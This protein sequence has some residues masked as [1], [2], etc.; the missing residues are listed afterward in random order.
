MDIDRFNFWQTLPTVLEAISLAN[1]VSFDLEMSGIPSSVGVSQPAESTFYHLAAEAAR[2]FQILQVGLT[3]LSYDCKHKG[4]EARTFTFQLTPE[5]F[6]PNTTLAKLIDRKLVLSYRSF[7]FLKENNF[8]FEKTFSQGVPYL[9]R[10]EGELANNLYLTKPQN[11]N[12]ATKNARP[13]RSWDSEYKKRHDSVVRQTGKPI[14][15][16]PTTRPKQA[17][18]QTR[19]PLHH[20]SPCRRL[21]RRRSRPR[22]TPR[23]QAPPTHHFLPTIHRLPTPPK[24]PPLRSPPPRPPPHPHR[25]Q[26]LP[27]PLLPA[28]DLPAAPARRRPRLPPRHTPLL[29]AHHRHQAP[30]LPAR[31]ETE[32]QP[33]TAL[34]RSGW[35]GPQD[36]P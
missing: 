17:N 6:P 7:L 5:F 22:T 2:T 12:T 30:G 11:P 25:P 36:F 8:S 19:I 3:C 23:R 10:S 14:N 29:P 4:Y 21:L 33:R 20:R 32:P 9:S 18:T 34:C 28:R 1:Y 31:L 27:R 35:Q 16:P 13:Q 24:P 26:P 15:T